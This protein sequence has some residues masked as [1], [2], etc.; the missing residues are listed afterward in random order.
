[1]GAQLNAKAS[2]K[3]SLA[4]TVTLQGDLDRR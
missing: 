3:I 2:G 1:L 4:D